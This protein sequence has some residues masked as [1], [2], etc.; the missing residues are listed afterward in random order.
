MRLPDLKSGK[1]EQQG[2]LEL[3]STQEEEN[4]YNKKNTRPEI[5]NVAATRIKVMVAKM[6]I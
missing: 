4:G 2:I 6:Q 5:A 1:T 3:R